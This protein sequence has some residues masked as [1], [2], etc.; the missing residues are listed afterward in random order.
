MRLKEFIIFIIIFTII[1]FLSFYIYDTVTN[2]K[3]LER[4][5]KEIDSLIDFNK[6]IKFANFYKIN[7]KSNIEILNSIFKEVK[8]NKYNNLADLSS[9]YSIEIIEVVVIILYLEYIGVIEKRKIVLSS[10][11]TTPFN[12]NDDALLVKYSLFFSNKYDY[13][14]ITKRIGVNSDKDL[15]YINDYFLFPGVIIKDNNIYYVGDL[16]D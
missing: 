9:K 6:Y 14:T 4:R 15:I 1:Y 2:K 3:A 5:K 10:N 16:N 8:I 11:T 13:Q 12:S 7:I